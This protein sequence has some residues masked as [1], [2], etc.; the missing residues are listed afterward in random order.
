MHA[1]DAN[2]MLYLL[3]PPPPRA[4]GGDPEGGW[5]GWGGGGGVLKVSPRSI[6]PRLGYV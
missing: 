4:G 3:G 2:G 5:G 6:D 1:N